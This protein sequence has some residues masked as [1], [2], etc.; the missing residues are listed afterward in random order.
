MS[1][2]R[3]WQRDLDVAAPTPGR[4]PPDFLAA[5]TY[6]TAVNKL[7]IDRKLRVTGQGGLLTPDE[8]A[9][10]DAA[11]HGGLTPAQ[12]VDR[13]A[14][15]AARVV[16]WCTACSATFSDVAAANDHHEA[17]HHA[18]TWRPSGA[19]AA[20]VRAFVPPTPVTP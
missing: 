3:A 1:P 6:Q 17:T 8:M 16:Y 14:E 19:F 20:R 12:F 10:L 4:I 5:L 11:F 7:V 9:E 2:T 13:L 15:R 18:A